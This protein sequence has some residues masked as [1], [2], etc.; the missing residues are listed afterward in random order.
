[1]RISEFSSIIF[2]D[3]SYKFDMSYGIRQVFCNTDKIKVCVSM[4]LSKNESVREVAFTLY[5]YN[6]GVQTGNIIWSGTDT[7]YNEFVHTDENFVVA[8]IGKAIMALGG[9]GDFSLSIES[10]TSIIESEVFKVCA[11]GSECLNDTLLLT[12]TNNRNIYDTIFVTE[13]VKVGGA[14][15]YEYG[16]VWTY[17]GKS[18]ILYSFRF[19]GSLNTRETDFGGASEIFTSQLGYSQL[20]SGFKKDKYTLLM[21]DNWGVPTGFGRKFRNALLCSSV[22]LGEIMVSLAEEQSINR[23]EIGDSYPF[24]RFSAK[25]SMEYDEWGVGSRD[26]PIIYLTNNAENKLLTSNSYVKLK[27]N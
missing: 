26:L 22:C 3:E 4:D 21:G 27:Q 23:E 15:T 14:T 19:K 9:T 1:M 24:F 6:D 20:L 18:S 5:K 11:V 17:K 7:T 25:I 2:N 8:D 13:D 12:Y 16:Q 10:E